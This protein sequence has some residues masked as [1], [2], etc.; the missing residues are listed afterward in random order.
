MD[1]PTTT[2]PRHVRVAIIGAGFGGLGTAIRLDRQGDD[3][4]LVFE[5]AEDVGGTWWANTYPGCQ[6]DIPSHL[7]SFSFAPNPEWTRTY[8]E[9][10]E[11]RDYLRACVT[12]FGIADRIRLR[13]EVTGADWDEAAGRWA[14]Q[15]SA[16]P[17]TADVLVAA[18]G[19]LSAPS[20]PDLPGLA[21]FAGTVFHTARW[22][23]DHDL[24]G[25]R[26]AFV[27]TG[28]SAIQAVPEVQRVAGHLDVFQRTPPWVVPH[29]DRP[30][31]RA[32]RA[33]YRRVPVAQRLVRSVVYGLRELLV[34]GLAY[35]PALMG[36][37]QRLAL[38]HLADQVPDPA[39]R[40][41]VTP[42]YAIGCK[43]I[44]PSNR[45]YP[46]LGAPNV[47]LVT[48]A[49]AAV[50]PDGVV[51][52]DGA[53]H[54]ADTIIFGTGFHVTDI[55]LAGIVRGVGGRRLADVW[56][57]SP[58]AYRGT[59]VAGFPNLFLLVGPNVGLGHNSIVFMIEAQITYLLG[60]LA[61]MRRRG[62]GRVEVRP[63]AQAAYNV[64]LQ[65]RMGR[66]VW[67]TGGCS[68]W[69]L[70]ATG[71]NTTIWPDFTWRFWAQARRFDAAAYD[72]APAVP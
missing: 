9:Q 68:S 53:F 47:D 35:R 21:D 6:C 50:R 63:A 39:L 57:R 71:R 70:D 26:V 28:A 44:L 38:K 40:A 56:D 13:T 16:G 4:F 11:I 15:T 17:F 29:R 18:P 43:R 7:Y 14:L 25:R 66:T 62:A 23:H 64:G 31:T 32:E 34:P 61:E 52:A 1:V 45:W 20:V 19:P 30:I 54:P 67:N 36:A 27:G 49:I 24:T 12:R 58:Q 59:A 22:N 2:P 72:L 8:P 51:S 33:L 69:Y 5:R 37:V 46:A 42:D 60:A 55:P 10:P 3:D 41:R 48:S 65:G